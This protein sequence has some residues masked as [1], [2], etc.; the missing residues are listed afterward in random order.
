MIPSQLRYPRP[1]VVYATSS[2]EIPSSGQH[3]APRG[4]RGQVLF[5]GFCLQWT[6]CAD[7]L[8]HEHSILSPG[9]SYEPDHSD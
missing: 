9:R 3:L 2:G 6:V 8:S 4:L 1:E 7:F 5:R